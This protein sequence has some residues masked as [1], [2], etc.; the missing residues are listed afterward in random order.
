MIEIVVTIISVV[1]SAVFALMTRLWAGFAYFVLAL[2]MLLAIFWGIVLI[3]KFFTDYKK[4]LQEEYTLF[5]AGKVNSS[6]ISSK[7]FEENESVYKKEF[8]KKMLKDKILKWFV[9]L[10]C[11]AVALTFLLGMIFYK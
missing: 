3:I 2:L 6:Q 7:T 1:L 5:K 8:S 9:I 4:E 11:F 10:F